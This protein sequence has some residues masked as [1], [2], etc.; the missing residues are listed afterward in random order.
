[1]G[2]IPKQLKIVK[3][4]K[5]LVLFP[6]CF[7]IAV[8]NVNYF[9]FS[10]QTFSILLIFREWVFLHFF[11]SVLFLL[12]LYS[13]SLWIETFSSEPTLVC[14]HTPQWA[15][16]RTQRALTNVT[17]DIVLISLVDIFQSSSYMV[18]QELFKSW[19]LLFEAFP[20]L[21]S[22]CGY[23][24]TSLGALSTILCHT[25]EVNLDCVGASMYT[26]SFG[27]SDLQPRC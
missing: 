23:H 27:F 21:V 16:G 3:N 2:F 5:P 7:V 24:P 1:M 9:Q 8:N 15:R 13:Y 17:H 12:L 20:S 11:F 14:L 22:G 18:F 19:P 26:F 25:N 4:S 10:F 6:R